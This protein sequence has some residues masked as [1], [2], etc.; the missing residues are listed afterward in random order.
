MLG[1]T[2]HYAGAFDASSISTGRTLSPTTR[3]G[4]A[5]D[6]RSCPTLSVDDVCLSSAILVEPTSVKTIAELFGPAFWVLQRTGDR[7]GRPRQT[8]LRTVEDDLRP[9]NF[10]LA[11]AK[12]RATDRS[13]WRLLVETATST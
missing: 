4:L 6:N 1:A 2:L 12:R 5:L 9:I 10:G 7:V 3:S 13:A 8:W 11:T